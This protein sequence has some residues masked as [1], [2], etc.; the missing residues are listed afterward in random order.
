MPRKN[1]REMVDVA[2]SALGEL[3]VSTP[4]ELGFGDYPLVMAADIYHDTCK[5][6]NAV[7][8]VRRS[9]DRFKML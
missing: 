7:N 5:A 8:R 4:N 1:P 9:L 3:L 2:S 6:I